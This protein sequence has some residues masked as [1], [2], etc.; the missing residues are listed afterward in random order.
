MLELIAAALKLITPDPE[1][2]D[3]R[4]SKK[5]LKLQLKKLRKAR[6][7]YKR[8]RRYYKDDGIS[9]VEQES[10]NTLKNALIQREIDLII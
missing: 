5:E 6:K 9:K 3:V 7:A 1:M 8:I 10:L 4:L 2:K